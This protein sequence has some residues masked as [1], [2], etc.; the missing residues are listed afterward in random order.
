M[1]KSQFDFLDE[2]KTLIDVFLASHKT[3]IRNDSHMD[4]HSTSNFHRLCGR[5]ESSLT[6]ENHP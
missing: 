3:V 2:E 1:A 5:G 6:I 4:P